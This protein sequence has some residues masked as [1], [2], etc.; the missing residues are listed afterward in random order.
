MKGKP[1][2]EKETDLAKIREELTTISIAL[3]LM[4]IDQVDAADADERK[5]HEKATEKA[6]DLLLKRI[7][8]R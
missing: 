1:V 2:S 4:A 3:S 5:R 6:L 8:A 7:E